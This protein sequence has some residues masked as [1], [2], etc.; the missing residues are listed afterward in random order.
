MTARQQGI[1]AAHDDR[2]TGDV[3]ENPYPEGTEQHREWAVGYSY[4]ESL[5]DNVTKSP[6]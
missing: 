2:E 5:E 1:S 3:T 6:W 4:F